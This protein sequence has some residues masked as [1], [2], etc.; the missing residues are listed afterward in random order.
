MATWAD[1]NAGRKAATAAMVAVENCILKAIACD[2]RE[3]EF[4]FFCKEVWYIVR[5][6]T[7]YVRAD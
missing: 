3:D 6:Q 5:N 2:D 1:T 7:N 4:G